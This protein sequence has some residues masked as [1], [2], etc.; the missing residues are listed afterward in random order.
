[1]RDP[2]TS[3]KRSRRD[4]SYVAS[5]EIAP[6]GMVHLHVLLLGEYVP[7]WE[8]QA[9]WSKALGAKAIVHVTAI[10]R[11]A[12][13]VAAGLREVL[14]YATKGEKRA[15]SSSRRA[16]AVELAFRN[17]KRVSIGGALRNDCVRPSDADDDDTQPEDLHAS[18]EM[19][20]L[21][22]GEV[23]N[24]HWGGRVD[25]AVVVRNGGYGPLAAIPPSGGGEAS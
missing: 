14:K 17:I 25:P 20:C 24:W 21:V 7:Q 5:E 6:R 11:G 23:G 12:A 2:L 4:T 8:L 22:C 10:R 19:H 9:L 1:M 15:R 16:A 3:K 18:R 13:G